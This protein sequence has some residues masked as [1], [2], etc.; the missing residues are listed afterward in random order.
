MDIFALS[1]GLLGVTLS[2]LGI[3]GFAIREHKME[4]RRT[5]SELAA[6]DHKT[7]KEFRIILWTCGSLISV[8]MYLL[9]LPNITAGPWLYIFYTLV[10]ICE[11]SLAIISARGGRLGRLH[12]SLAYSMAFGMLA[13][14]LSFGLLLSGAI[15]ALE[16]T[17]F[18][19]MT[20]LTVFALIYS[21]HFLYFELPFIFL[22]H[23]TLV[24]AAFTLL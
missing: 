10:I 6:R 5:L 2:T 14:A 1:C 3:L 4:K 24:L 17:L 18:S 19:F 12:D 22:S 21:E 15:A 13:L 9:V 11:L 8:M 7:L 23:L 16:Y 20:L